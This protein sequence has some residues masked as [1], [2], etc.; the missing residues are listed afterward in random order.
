MSDADKAVALFQN[1]CACS[2]AILGTYGQRYGMDETQALRV[3]AGFAGGMRRAETCGAVTGGLM[4]LGLAWCDGEACRTIDGRRE[5]YGAVIS[6]ATEF[7]RRHGSLECRALLGVD[8]S[9]PEGAQVAEERGLFR[10]RCVELVRDA[11]V[12][13]E[14]RLPAVP[15]VV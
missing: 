6:L 12:L 13:L 3:A 9:T 1:G 8:V 15:P 7:E 14:E 5:A 2:Q 4:V 11:A 10:T